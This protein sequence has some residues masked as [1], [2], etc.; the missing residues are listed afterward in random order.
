ML[1]VDLET[2]VRGI[3]PAYWEANEELYRTD[4]AARNRTHLAGKVPHIHMAIREAR[5]ELD[6]RLGDAI[7]TAC[8]ENVDATKLSAGETV[9]EVWRG[10][11]LLTQTLER[12]RLDA[13]DAMDSSDGDARLEEHQRAMLLHFGAVAAAEP[14]KG[15]LAALLLRWV[16]APEPPRT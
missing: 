14:L 8:L 4:R 1:E 13:A 5:L 6:R 12:E 2:R 3:F 10:Y 9:E 15:L 16:D 7:A 11:E